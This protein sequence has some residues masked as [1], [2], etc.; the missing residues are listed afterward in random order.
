M[1]KPDNET[2]VVKSICNTC[3]CTCG[4]LVHVRNGRVIKIEGDTEH[5]ANEG[6]RCVKGLA[7]TQ[8]VYHPDRLKYPMKRVGERGEGKWQ[9]IS[10][11]EALDTIAARIKQ[12]KEES[13][14]E[15][16]ALC[17]DEGK[18][19]SSMEFHECPGQP[20]VVRDRCSLLLPP[21][22]QYRHDDIRRRQ[23]YSLRV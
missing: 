22:W 15:S 23:L 14:P 2:R 17:W 13:G 4:V 5:P 21:Q 8:L 10:W 9:R 6:A 11:D 3:H 12:A 1:D 16:I 20:D 19:D 18:R 7:Y